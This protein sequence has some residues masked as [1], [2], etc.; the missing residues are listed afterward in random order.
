MR[1]PQGV[2]EVQQLMGKI[3]ALSRFIPRS[4]K[5]AQPIFGALK[6]GRR[7]TW[8]SEC[9]EAF[10]KTKSNDRRSTGSDTSGPRY[11]FE[12][13]GEQR[14]VYFVSKILQGP[15]TRYQKIEKAAL[16]L[17]IASRRLRLYFQNF[18]IIVR[19][20]LPIRQ[21]LGKPNL[22]ERMVAWSVQL[23][24]FDIS[25]ERRGHIKAQAITDFLVEGESYLSIDGSS[26]HTRSEAGIILEGP[27]GVLIKQ[28]L[29]FEFKAS[30]NQAEYE[31]LLTGMKLA[32]EVGMKKLMAKSD[33]KL[34]TG[35]I[36]G[37]YQAKDP[38]LAKYQD[39]ASAMASSFD[40][41][42]LLHVP[43]YQNER[44]DLLVKLANTQRRGQ[45]RTIIYEKLSTSTIDRR[46]FSF[47]LLRCLGDEE[48]TYVIKEVH[49]GVCGTHIGGRTLASKIARANYYWPTLRRD[50][51]EYVKICDKCQKFAEGHKAPPERLHP[52]TS[53]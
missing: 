11:P 43:S 6:K 26:N 39:R 15:E 34:V 25:F 40:N 35:K 4:A 51:L 7:F 47:P 38:Q 44:A 16:A 50:C 20:Y 3:T 21:V 33:S 27:T 28:S 46:G 52:I 37:D 10:Q 12:R 17:V 41:F 53:P 48:S 9:E 49:E 5:T 13:E 45:Q 8:T 2:K 19:T 30:N 23:S 32:Q 24:E 29:H 18:S 36:N 31:A 14:P 1:S 42:V 22:A